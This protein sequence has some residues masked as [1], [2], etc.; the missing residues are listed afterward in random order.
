VNP[1]ENKPAVNLYLFD[2]D[3]QSVRRDWN[4]LLPVGYQ[5]VFVVD[6]AFQL[7]AGTGEVAGGVVVTHAS[8]FAGL[9]SRERES[10]LA[11]L[12]PRNLYLVIVSGGEANIDDVEHIYQRKHP[13]GKQRGTPDAGFRRCFA[14]FWQDFRLSHRPDFS[15]LEPPDTHWL[16]DLEWLCAGY[17]VAMAECDAEKQIQPTEL[18][19]ALEPLGLQ[20]LQSVEAALQARLVAQRTW[21]T[22]PANWVASLGGNLS[23]FR[24][25]LTAEF[26]RRFRRQQLPDGIASL[27]AALAGTEPISAAIV[28]KAARDIPRSV[29]RAGCAGQ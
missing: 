27:L 18:T 16:S 14:D 6:R 24:S 1:S 3:S 11:N 29:S 9:S 13:V 2:T 19:A 4:A 23:R 20:G 21:F 10:V 8:S 26:A 5:S 7:E 25:L 15:L 12:V 22:T 17:V 28:A